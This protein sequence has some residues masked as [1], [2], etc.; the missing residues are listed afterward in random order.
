MPVEEEIG[1][2][3]VQDD[4][5]GAHARTLALFDFAADWVK[6]FYSKKQLPFWQGAVTWLGYPPLI[7]LHPNFKKGSYLK[8]YQR[9]EVLAHEAVH[10]MRLPLA[11]KRFEEH[12]AY[13]T[14]KSAW[15]RWLGPLFHT[16]KESSLFLLLLLCSVLASYLLIWA[17]ALTLLKLLIALPWLALAYGLIRLSLEHR[18]LRTC[19]KNLRDVIRNPQKA[20]ALMVRLTDQEI[21]TFAALSS[22]HIL[23]YALLEQERSLRWR[24]LF[25]AYF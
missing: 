13:Q 6:A 3:L 24:Q 1:E 10:A 7:Q 14:S 18:T 2:P 8:L 23:A 15:R 16:S 5:K 25:L 22:A 11:S 20:R 21:A 9:D 4:W 17:P 12:F 19:E